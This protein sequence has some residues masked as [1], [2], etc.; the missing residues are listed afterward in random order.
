MLR[1]WFTMFP[2]LFISMPI[3][4][5]FFK[6]I[7][8]AASLPL[9]WLFL[10]IEFILGL[11]WLFNMEKS[12]SKFDWQKCTLFFK[13]QNLPRIN[14]VLVVC[15][16]VVMPFSLIDSLFFCVNTWDFKQIVLAYKQLIYNILHALCKIMIFAVLLFVVKDI[17]Q[18]FLSTE[19]LKCNQH[20]FC[21]NNIALSLFFWNIVIAISICVSRVLVHW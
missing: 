8:G 16:F 11:F 7:Y 5:V 19:A 12:V 10:A 21:N 17:D 14:A 3:I 1:T 20:I 4:L 18:W 13:E 15:V 2:F 9:L 6:V